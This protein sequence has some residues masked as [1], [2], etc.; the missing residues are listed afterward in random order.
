MLK[1]ESMKALSFKQ[2]FAWLIVNGYLSVDERTWYTPYRGLLAVHASKG[3]YP[4][5]YNY[6]RLHTEWPMPPADAFEYGGLVGVATL[7]DCLMP[8]EEAK[9][10]GGVTRAHNGPPGCYG[11]EFIN[12]QPKS[13]IALPGKTGIFDLPSFSWPSV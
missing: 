11:F 8:L 12:P 5:Y 6:F 1:R 3:F 10:H 9:R 7:N 2:P 13:F 4:E